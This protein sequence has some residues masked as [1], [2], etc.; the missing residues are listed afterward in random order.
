MNV[1]YD[2]LPEN[3]F[4]EIPSFDEAR[5][6]L[7]VSPNFFDIVDVKNVYMEGN[8]NAVNK[9]LALSQ[10]EE[11]RNSYYFAQNIGLIND[12]NTIPGTQDLEDMVFCANQT[13]PWLDTDGRKIVVLSKM[14][15]SSR[16]REVAHFIPF[17]KDQNYRIIQFNELD[18]YKEGLTFEGMGDAIP[19]PGK[20][21]I[22]GGYGHRT[23]PDVYKMLSKVLETP[24]IAL[25]LVSPHFYHL[26]TCFVPLSE[27]TVM[28]CPQAFSLESYRLIEKTFKKIVRIPPSEAITTF[29]LNAHTLRLPAKKTIT[30]SPSTKLAILQYG[31]TYTYNCLLEEG[32]TIIELETSEFMKSGGSVFCMKMMYF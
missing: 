11:L 12:V 24:I 9:A 21:L 2:T 29:S 19:H 27:N 3:F 30:E 20:R 14:R 8:H 13:F 17:F 25:R 26:D 15:H 28:L 22:Y 32:Y 23:S 7:L 10:W 4:Q 16:E 5:N 1:F 6:V 18:G 31:S